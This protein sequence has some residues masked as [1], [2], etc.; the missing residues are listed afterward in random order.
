[1]TK[2]GP[3][4]KID[5]SLMAMFAL[6]V[7]RIHGAKPKPAARAAI[8]A[9]F[10]WTADE[11][12]AAPTSTPMYVMVD[13]FERRVLKALQRLNSGERSV[14]PE[15]MR[16]VGWCHRASGAPVFGTPEEL[17]QAVATF[18]PTQ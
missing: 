9:Y 8:R 16:A 10:S 5:V 11:E 2:R 6:L 7:V 15:I 13:D 18:L 4:Q 14:H 1:M 3:K 12:R 17:A